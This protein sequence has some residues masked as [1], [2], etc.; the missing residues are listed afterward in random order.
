MFWLIAIPLLA[1]VLISLVRAAVRIR[2]LSNTRRQLHLKMM[3][4]AYLCVKC[5][6]DVRHN[7]TGRCPE[8]GTEIEPPPVV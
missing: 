4:D 5:G 8:C 2:R 1:L 7:E 3:R 6:Y